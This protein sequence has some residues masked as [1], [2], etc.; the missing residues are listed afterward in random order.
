ML[1]SFVRADKAVTISR[2]KYPE[3][4]PQR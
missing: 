2:G 4:I 3:G 1:S